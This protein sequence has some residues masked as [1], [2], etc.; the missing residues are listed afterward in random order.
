MTMIASGEI[1]DGKTIMLL[2]Y[3]ALHLLQTTRAK[4]DL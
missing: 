2:Q 3:A 1:Q 4:T